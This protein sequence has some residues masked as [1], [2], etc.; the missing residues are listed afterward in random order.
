[1]G[2]QEGKEKKGNIKTPLEQRRRPP[3]GVG[4]VRSRLVGGLGGEISTN[5]TRKGKKKKGKKG[6]HPSRRKRYRLQQTTPTA[7]TITKGGE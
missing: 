2:A 4:G 7:G 1:V 6:Y 5:T 3:V